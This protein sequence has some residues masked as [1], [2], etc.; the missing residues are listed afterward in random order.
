MA[1]KKVHKVNN[2]IMQTSG[3]GVSALINSHY[4]KTGKDIN[5]VRTLG[6]RKWTDKNRVDGMCYSITG[7]YASMYNVKTTN[8]FFLQSNQ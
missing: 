5:E 2:E 4:C 1:I 6:Q 3:I 7:Q 8:C